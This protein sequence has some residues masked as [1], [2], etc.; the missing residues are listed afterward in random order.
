MIIGKIDVTKIDKAKLF[1]G[2]N[3]TYLDKGNNP[4]RS[5]SPQTKFPD[6]DGGSPV[7]F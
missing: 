7:P 4:P 5:Q 1:K 2:A 6:I 3:G